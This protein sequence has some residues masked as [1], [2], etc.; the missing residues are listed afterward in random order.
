LVAAADVVNSAL[1]LGTTNS[2]ELLNFDPVASAIGANAT[3]SDLALLSVNRQLAMV[4]GATA[5]LISG[6]ASEET[7]AAGTSST[8]GISAMA[9][10]MTSRFETSSVFSLSNATDMQDFVQTS[11]NA[12]N[13]SGFTQDLRATSESDIQVLAQAMSGYNTLIDSTTTT[14]NTG[15]QSAEAIATL[16]AASTQLM[17]AFAEIGY[18][19]T[20]IR[21]GDLSLTEASFAL[22]ASI[23]S[24]VATFVNAQVTTVSQVSTVFETATARGTTGQLIALDIQLP[25]LGLGDTLDTFNI[26]SLPDGLALLLSDPGTGIASPLLAIDGV[27][28]VAPEDVGYLV[29][30]TDNALSGTLRIDGSNTVEGVTTN[31]QGSLTVAVKAPKVYVTSSIPIVTDDA[32]SIKG[33]VSSGVNSDD[34]TP[35]LS[36]TLST[37]PVEGEKVQIFDGAN[38]LGLASITGK[39]WSFTPAA[40]LSEGKHS[41][42]ARVIDLAGSVHWASRP[43]DFEVDTLSP[44]LA[45]ATNK[46]SLKRDLE[47]LVG[48]SIGPQGLHRKVFTRTWFQRRKSGHQRRPLDLYRCRR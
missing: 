43:F 33:V 42:V 7:S 45:I 11:L 4:F 21:G 25:A 39:E 19:A 16:R 20:S 23:G 13:V 24:D 6:A 47:R 8:F 40:P 34:P 17:P 9:D 10:L 36:G 32:G 2:T 38:L 29:I 5:S 37:L 18:Q 27:Y 14:A 44:S 48:Q 31:Y 28:T 26:S 22:T 35:T 41:L 30:R 1:G 12:S 3:A 15:G 46:T